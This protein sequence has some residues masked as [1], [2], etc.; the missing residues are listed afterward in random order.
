MKLAE[1]AAKLVENIP[2]DD[3]ILLFCLVDEVDKFNTLYQF[4]KEVTYFA[5]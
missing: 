1:N 2:N 4:H 3:I 5:L